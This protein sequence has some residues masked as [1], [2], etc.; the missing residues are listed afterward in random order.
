VA[1]E[2]AP[3][4]QRSL[5]TDTSSFFI[6]T[7]KY[8]RGG[9]KDAITYAHSWNDCRVCILRKRELARVCTRKKRFFGDFVWTTDWKIDEFSI[10]LP[11]KSYRFIYIL[12]M[13]LNSIAKFRLRE[14]GF[15]FFF[16]TSTDQQVTSRTRLIR[17]SREIIFG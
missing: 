2:L 8:A 16:K 3:R 1:S 5:T 4:T 6:F 9:G 14:G 13:S 7:M 15:F 17:K 10:L 11:K 12:R